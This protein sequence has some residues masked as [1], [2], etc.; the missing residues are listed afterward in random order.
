MTLLEIVVSLAEHRNDALDALVLER[1]NHFA[2]QVCREKKNDNKQKVP[3][4]ITDIKSIAAS[5]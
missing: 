4:L 1:Q 3:Q 2:K 5:L